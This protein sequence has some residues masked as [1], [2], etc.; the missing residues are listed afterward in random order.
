M[1]YGDIGAPVD[2]LE[3]DPTNANW[4]DIIH[5]AG[6]IYAIAYTDSV[7]DDWVITVDI[8]TAGVIDNTIKGSLRFDPSEGWH[9]SIVHVAG[10]IYAIAYRGVVTH[11]FVVT[12]NITAAGVITAVA[13]SKLEFETDSC[14]EPEMIKVPDGSDVFAI[15]CRGNANQGIINTVTI[16]DAG[17][18][19]AIQMKEAWKTN[20][21]NPHIIHI[22]GSVFAIVSRDNDYDGWVCTMIINAA[23]Q[24]ST[25]VVA[26]LEFDPAFG[27]APDICHVAGE[28]YAIAYRENNNKGFVLTVAITAGGAI[29]AVGGVAGKL[30]FDATKCDW[31]NIIFLAGGICAIA[32]SGIDDDGFVVT[33]KIDA[34]GQITALDSREHDLF[35]GMHPSIVRVSGNQYAIAYT[36][37]GLHGF[38]DTPT[39][40]TPIPSG[41]LMMMGIG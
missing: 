15:V 18:T 23:G 22:S 13:G 32:Y 30:E 6:N 4:T 14:Y 3:F 27:I 9:P 10:E 36:G 21:N 37:N 19:S 40:V 11:G 28:I 12:V 34:A 31:P 16:T 24:I 29:S 2:T 8:S 26:E 20:I 25:D 33:V 41:H 35:H 5:V 38:L 39:I 17:A 1:A 7:G